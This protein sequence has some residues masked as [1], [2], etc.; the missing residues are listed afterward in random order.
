MLSKSTE[1][2]LTPAI[3]IKKLIWLPSQSSTGENCLFLQLGSNIDDED[4]DII[5]SLY[6]MLV[7]LSPTGKYGE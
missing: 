1:E 6:Y 4:D 2:D 7:G 3:P 5:D